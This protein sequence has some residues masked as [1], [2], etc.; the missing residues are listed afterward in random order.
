MTLAF[1]DGSDTLADLVT[2]LKDQLRSEVP[3]GVFRGTI[4]PLQPLQLDEL[5][6][7]LAVPSELHRTRLRSETLE[8][9]EAIAS[10][11]LERTVQVR[12][13]VAQMRLSTD[14]APGGGTVGAL[15]D[16]R[17]STSSTDLSSSIDLRDRAQKVPPAATS[18]GLEVGKYT[19]DNFVI[20]NSNRF[21]HAAAVAASEAPGMKYTP[22]FIY[23]ESGL[24]KTHLL[25]AF[26]HNVNTLFPDKSCLFITTEEYLTQFV[27][28]ISSN[29]V[30]AF[31]T[32]MRKLDVLLI[33]DIQFIAGKSGLQEELFHTLNT[34]YDLGSQVVISCDS[35]PDGIQDLEE[36]LR[37]RFSQGLVVDVQPPDIETRMAILNSLAERIGFWLP[38]DVCALIANRVSDNVRS[39][40]G[41]LRQVYARSNLF[42]DAITLELAESVLRDLVSASEVHITVELILQETAQ[43]SGYTVDQLVSA[44]RKRALVEYRKIAMYLSRDMTNHSLAELGSFFDRDHTTVL[45]A[46]KTSEERLAERADFYDRYIKVQRAIQDRLRSAE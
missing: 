40:E 46:I 18:G 29:S 2:H 4:Q 12:V 3:P 36:R 9:M 15:N 5:V 11:Y 6:L 38:S 33:D 26:G 44:S 43:V 35:K 28:A 13:S 23:G 22:L 27:A 8:R 25:R 10:D 32:R 45:H 17:P 42:N 14:S 34:L 41:A 1:N 21:A 30:P 7:D 16:Q 37:T 24:G 19:F 31:A 20:G 39:L